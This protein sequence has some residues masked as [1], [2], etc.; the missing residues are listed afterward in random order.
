MVSDFSQIEEKTKSFKTCRDINQF[1]LEFSFEQFKEDNAGL[2][3]VKDL[4]EQLSKWDRNITKSIKL[5][6][7]KGLIVASGR[8]IKERFQNRVKKEQDNLR[9]YLFDLADTTNRE[10]LSG[11][12][13]M[14]STLQKP[15]SNLT[16][17]VEYVNKLQHSKLQFVKL[18]DQKKKFEEMKAVLGK[19][20][21]K[22]E[23]AY[24]N[25][26][27]ISS[28]QTKID[29][30]AD[31]LVNVDGLIKKA[32]EIAAGNKEANTENLSG[33]IQ[34]EQE[35][36]R[37]LIDKIESETLMNKSTNIKDALTDLKKLEAN[38]DKTLA[39]VSEYRSYEQTLNVAPAEIPEIEAFQTKFKKRHT[40]WNNWE[41]FTNLKKTWYTTNF[42]DQDAEAI[43]KTVSKYAKE[44]L[45]MKAKMSKEDVDEVL[46]EVTK[47]VNEVVGHKNLLL[48]LGSKAM[49]QRH[50][51][52][53]FAALDRPMPNLDVGITMSLLLDDE[54]NAMDHVEEIED[55]SGGAQGEM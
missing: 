18:S 38:F 15:I 53:V 32:D 49:Q 3:K 20:R 34:K 25:S 51:V 11:I 10:I 7:K 36:I 4:F 48:A 21:I 1:D 13:S 41:T 27:K 47:E 28:L 44:N 50:W 55:I 24:S 2:E 17:Y 5:E 26:S 45:E 39:K 12:N 43:V 6:E 19:Y 31:E 46:D 42:K 9:N 29:F 33:E 54:H 40:I 8:K 14:K 52:K 23:N 37:E 35:K 16:T 30:I 22:D